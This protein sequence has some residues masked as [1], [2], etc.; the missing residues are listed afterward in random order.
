M[1]KKLT[2]NLDEEIIGFAKYFSKSNHQSISQI[3]E[4]YFKKLK[5]SPDDVSFSPKVNSLYGIFK[6]SNLPDKKKLRKEYHE[7]RIN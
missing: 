5:S 1:Y 3:V 7:S 4:N 6:S 2:L